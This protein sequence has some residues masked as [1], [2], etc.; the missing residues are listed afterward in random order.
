MSLDY[1]VPRKNGKYSF[2]ITVPKAKRAKFGKREFWITLG[3]KD[4]K[5]AIVKA[6]AL[7][8]HYMKLFKADEICDSTQLTMPLIQQTSERLGIQYHTPEA[9]EAASV[10]DYVAMMSRGIEVLEKIKKPDIAEVAA[11]GGAVEPPALNMLELF[12]RFV[13]LSGD[14]FLGLDKRARDKKANRYKA[15]ATDFVAIS[16]EMDVV[17]MTSKEAFDF[18]A[19]LTQRVAD[20]EIEL[21][22]AQKKLQHVGMFVRKVFQADYPTKPNPF[23]DAKIESNGAVQTGR[24]RQFTEPEIMALNAN[25]EDSGAND[26]LKAILAISEC[27]GASVKEICLLT[28][29]DFH[30]EEPFPFITIGPNKHR[31]FVKTGK[32]RHRD[33]PL[34][35]KALEAAKRYA[36]TGFP[37]YARPGGS[38]ALSAAA[39]KLI[40]PVAPGATTYSFRH[41]IAF[42]LQNTGCVDTMKNSLM[43]HHSPGMTMRYGDGYDMSNKYK[44]LKKALALAEKKQ[45]KLKN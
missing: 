2:R 44:A 31:K 32:S 6:A 20:E 9:I 34:I 43:G 4:R 23:K 5:E 33:I 3:T 41:R 10:Q 18:A 7:L 40:R 14:K 29:S 22:T 13:E 11:I 15:A 27:T 26:E 16:G 21:E 38:E 28:E 17:N 42:L 45:A 24:R 1:I 8:D 35:G 39:N 19:K 25:L 30:L 37:R 36:K 12:D